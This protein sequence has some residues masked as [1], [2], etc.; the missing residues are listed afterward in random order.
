MFFKRLSRKSAP[1]VLPIDMKTFRQR[2]PRVLT[3][4]ILCAF[5]ALWGYVVGFHRA[6]FF[7]QVASLAFLVL[8]GVLL[9]FWSHA[10]LPQLV[11]GRLK[12]IF[13]DAKSTAPLNLIRLC[14]L[15]SLGFL[16][17]LCV[18]QRSSRTPAFLK[19]SNGAYLVIF[20][21]AMPLIFGIAILNWGGEKRTSTISYWIL[22]PSLYTL[23][24][25]NYQISRFSKLSSKISS[26]EISP[27]DAVL[28]LQEMATHEGLSTIGLTLG[29][30]LVAPKSLDAK[31]SI[32]NL[33]KLLQAF[34]STPPYAL[35]FNPLL[36]LSPSSLVEVG[37]LCGIELKIR[38]SLG[39]HF[40]E[41]LGPVVP[42]DRR[43]DFEASL[44]VKLAK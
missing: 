32:D 2:L 22:N 36:L 42:E 16:G 8:S 13:P 7:L 1:E 19:I 9:T 23:T 25:E 29:A 12:D 27:S 18:K 41:R 33:L 31:T 40:L 15:F 38:A 11:R 44:L 26:K 34:D 6:N 24:S 4:Q 21:L 14:P 17:Y 3:Y 10:S 39:R 35:K 43:S 28:E 5:F 20:T 30:S 37:L